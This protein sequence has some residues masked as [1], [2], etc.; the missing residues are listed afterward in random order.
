M[1]F[2]AFPRMIVKIGPDGDL[3]EKNVDLLGKSTQIHIRQLL[4]IP[5]QEPWRN[6][7]TMANFSQ[8]PEC[9]SALYPLHGIY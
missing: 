7:R 2:V 4:R 9:N 8:G 5:I 6:Y 1:G 3:N